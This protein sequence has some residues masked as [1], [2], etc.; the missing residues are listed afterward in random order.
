M[1]LRNQFTETF[2]NKIFAENIVYKGKRMKL[3]D[4]STYE[5][6]HS[7]LNALELT[8]ETGLSMIGRDAVIQTS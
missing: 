7:N 4:A 6:V 5:M 2:Q 1:N 3:T 8:D